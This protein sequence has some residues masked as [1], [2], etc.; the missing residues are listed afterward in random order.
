MCFCLYVFVFAPK[1]CSV[2]SSA[3]LRSSSNGSFQGTWIW[4]LPCMLGPKKFK[5]R[6]SLA[7]VMHDEHTKVCFNHKADSKRS[8]TLSVFQS[9]FV[10]AMITVLGLNPLAPICENRH[11]IQVSRLVRLSHLAACLWVCLLACL[12]AHLCSPV[13]Q[14]AV[15]SLLCYAVLFR[16]ILCCLIPLSLS[17]FLLQ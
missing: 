13:Q 2:H 7:Q 6:L 8:L 5:C 14:Y 11:G 9:L 17:Q 10:D 3:H 16:P 12:S 4:V 1:S 15:S